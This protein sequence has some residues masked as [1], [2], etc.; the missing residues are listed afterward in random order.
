M[1]FLTRCVRAYREAALE[2]T[3]NEFVEGRENW[4]KEDQERTSAYFYSSTGTKLRARLSN[5][6]IRETITATREPKNIKHNNGIARGIWLC[7]RAVE[8][9]IPA[10]PL[11]V[12]EQGPAE[13]GIP[14]L[15]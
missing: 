11:S 10:R 13:A 2:Y 12:T 7:V 3:Y 4:T 6:A 8:D 9:H 5:Y 14:A 1:R 15:R